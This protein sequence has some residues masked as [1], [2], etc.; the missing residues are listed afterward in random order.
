MRIFVGIDL[1]PAVR[2]RIS[3]FVEGVEG[4]APEARWINP[5]SWHITLKFIGEQNPDRV[6]AVAERLRQIDGRAFEVRCSGYGFFPS[7][8][9]PRVFWTGIQGRSQL[10]ALAESIDEGM[11]KLGIPR[12]DRPYSPHLTLARTGGRSGSP[13]WKAGDGP[14]AK[15]AELE[16]QLS[17]IGELDFGTMMAHEFFLYQSQ[18]SASGSRY[19]K[20]ERFPLKSQP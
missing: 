18:L 5:E 3:R 4:F 12:E 15:F 6:D 9:A 19:T 13:K 2:S 7:A 17:T 1:D 20:L 16:K 8:K 11:V 14:N 10:P